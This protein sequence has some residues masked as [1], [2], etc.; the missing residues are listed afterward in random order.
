MDQSL[1]RGMID[2]LLYL[3]AGR[4]D[5]TFAIGVCARYQSKPKMSQITQVKRIMKYINGT[6]DYGIL[7]SHNANSLLT[8]YRD[9]DREDNADDRKST[10]GGCFLLGNNLISWFSKK[11]NSVFL[12]TTEAEYVAAGKSKVELLIKALSKEE[13]IL[14][15]DGIDEEEENEDRSDASD[16]EDATSSDED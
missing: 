1:Y 10:F 11:Q 4:L 3:T 13:G 6:S 9:A 12:S 16:D 15:G 14:K 8:G 7:Y 2:S 5:I